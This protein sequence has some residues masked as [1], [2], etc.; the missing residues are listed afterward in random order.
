M[1]PL[2]EETILY[3]PTTL[4]GISV[5][6]TERLMINMDKKLKQIP[7]VVRV[8]GKAGRSDTS[9]DSAPFS[10]METVVSVKPQ[11]EWRTKERFY[12]KLPNFTHFLFRSFAS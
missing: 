6:E 10:M 11:N 7:E 3:M 2:Y 1:P 4:P 9:T 5:A 8:F 12:S